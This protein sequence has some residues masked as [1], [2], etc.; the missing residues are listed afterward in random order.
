MGGIESL[1]SEGGSNLSVGQRQLLCMGRALLRRARVLVMDE[2]TASVDPASDALIQ[3]A[4]VCLEWA[5][6]AHISLVF[7]L[8]PA[9]HTQLPFVKSLTT[10]LCLP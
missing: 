4:V 7:G 1:V 10:A 3:G 2:A 8:C 6:A 9:A 5:E